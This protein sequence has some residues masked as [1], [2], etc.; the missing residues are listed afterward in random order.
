MNYKWFRRII[1]GL[2]FTSA[3]FIFQAC[4][5]SPQDGFDDVLVE[6]QVTSSTTGKPLNG[7]QVEI[8][9]QNR[10]L[11][12]D[13]DGRFSLYVM[14][15]DSASVRFNE[16]DSIQNSYTLLKD[17]LIL[18]SVDVTFLDIKLDSSK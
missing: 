11:F 15:D 5:G 3:L 13:A 1:G 6:G 12:T 17:T 14:I 9:S 7:I 10:T 18:F 8:P 2:S 4:Y 16:Y